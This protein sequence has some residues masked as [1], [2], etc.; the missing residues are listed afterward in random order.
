M[1]S[2]NMSFDDIIVTADQD[3]LAGN[4]D[5]GSLTLESN[6]PDIYSINSNDISTITLD[7]PYT[8]KSMHV[9]GNATITG[10]LQVGGVSIVD[11]I[12]KINDRLAILKPNAELE[13]RW[14]KLRNLRE[15]YV[16]LEREILE[17]EK[18]MNILH[19]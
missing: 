17:Q 7:Y 9:D 11:A 10:D 5:F 14:E 8:S 4:I 6:I 1:N 15:Q 2:M 13:S 3:L 16:E 18:I 12:E 19:S